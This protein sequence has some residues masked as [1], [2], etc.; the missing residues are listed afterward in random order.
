MKTK[1]KAGI[2]IIKVNSIYFDKP[3]YRWRLNAKNGRTIAISGESFKTKASL[4]KSLLA[5]AKFF[6]TE[7]LFQ[8]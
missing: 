5:V 8:K 1:K 3:Q 7:M 2:E 4:E 6:R